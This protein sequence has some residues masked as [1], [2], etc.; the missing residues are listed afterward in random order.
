VD[1]L[2]AMSQIRQGGVM[3]LTLSDGDVMIAEEDL[4]IEEK[5]KEGYAVISDRGY[6][7]VLDT[8]LT[9]ELIEE[10][11][12]REI[13]SKIQSMRKDAGF[14]VMDHITIYCDGNDKVAEILTRNSAEISDDTLAENIVTGSVDGYNAQWDINGENVTLGVKKI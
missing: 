11:F 2:K 10:G 14:E 9:P 4:L 8:T 12:V 1:G 13:V 7:V 6:T 3:T 5:Q